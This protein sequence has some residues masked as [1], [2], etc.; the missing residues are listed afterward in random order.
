MRAG[1]VDVMT[2]LDRFDVARATT[3]STLG[4]L[5]R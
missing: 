2:L 4:A 1:R 5:P 3:L